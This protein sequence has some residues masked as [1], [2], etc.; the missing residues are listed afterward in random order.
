[1]SVADIDLA[2]MLTDAEKDQVDASIE[3]VS[4]VA[5]HLIQGYLFTIMSDDATKEQKANAE[6]LMRDARALTSA[7][8]TLRRIGG[9]E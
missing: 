2:L 5:S 9:D 8:A 3:S 4:E 1:L 7:L 6:W